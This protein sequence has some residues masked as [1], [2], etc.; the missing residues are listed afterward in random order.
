MRKA[1]DYFVLWLRIFFGVHLLY[2]SL[3]FFAGFEPQPQVP[4]LGG[5]FV[6][7]LTEMGL[8][9][10]IKG[11]EGVVGACLVTNLFVPLVLLVEMPVSVNIFYLNFIVVGTPRQLFSGPQEIILNLLLIIAYGSSYKA[12]LVPRARPGFPVPIATA[13]GQ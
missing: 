12:V 5:E 6:R 2:S 3:R 7:V 4:G 1:S 11:L 9:P 8:F 13:G 10:L